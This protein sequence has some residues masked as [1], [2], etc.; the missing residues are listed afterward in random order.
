M[1]ILFVETNQEL[2]NDASQAFLDK[3]VDLLA[4]ILEKPKSGIMARIAPGASFKLGETPDPA[5][6][7]EL[8]LFAFPEGKVPVYINALTDLLEKELGVAPDRQFH[9]FIQMAPAMFGWNGKPC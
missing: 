7:L 1:P 2:D 4:D 5:A 8:K 6:Y 3:A 9:E